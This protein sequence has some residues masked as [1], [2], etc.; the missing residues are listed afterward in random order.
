MNQALFRRFSEIGSD[1]G[2]Q[3]VISEGGIEVAP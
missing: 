3:A 2:S 1:I